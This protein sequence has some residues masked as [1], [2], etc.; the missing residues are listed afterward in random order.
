MRLARSRALCLMSQTA[1]HWRSVS[2]RKQERMYPPRLPMPI[3]PNVTRS[4]GGIA[5]SLPSADAG[6]NIGAVARTAPAFA[7]RFRSRRRLSVLVDFS[8]MLVSSDCDVERPIRDRQSL[9]LPLLS[10][11][12]GECFRLFRAFVQEERVGSAQ[13]GIAQHE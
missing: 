10:V 9:W 7:A 5:P 6:M 3:A 12:T 8:P 2:W 1:R 4:L 13:V 11:G